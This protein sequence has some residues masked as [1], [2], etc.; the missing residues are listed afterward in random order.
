[1]ADGGG[2]EVVRVNMCRTGYPPSRLHFVQG[3]VRATLPGTVPREIAFLRLDTDFYSTTLHELTYLYPLVAVNGVV[4]IDDYGWCEGAAR[5]RRVR[6]FNQPAPTS[7][8]NR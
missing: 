8:P 4:Y 1:M 7:Y 5:S 6:L 3:D 2:A